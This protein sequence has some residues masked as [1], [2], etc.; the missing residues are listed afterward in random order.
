MKKID[1]FNV[2]IVFVAPFVGN[3]PF[4]MLSQTVKE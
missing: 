4:V 2:D 3:N 1:S